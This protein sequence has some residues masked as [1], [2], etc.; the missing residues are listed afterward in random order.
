[1]SVHS[2]GCG[3]N[4]KQMQLPGDA[5]PAQVLAGLP[6]WDPE[7]QTCPGRTTGLWEGRRGDAPKKEVKEASC[8]PTGTRPGR[9]LCT[10]SCQ[11]PLPRLSQEQ[12]EDFFRKEF[13]LWRK[14]LLKKAKTKTGVPMVVQPVKNLTQGPRGCGAG[15][16]RPEVPFKN[17]GWGFTNLASPGPA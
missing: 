12:K 9:W 1:M 3:D 10:N 11:P 7:P 14:F 2:L 15:A 13:C 8:S 5:P 4:R 16:H 6:A 17:R